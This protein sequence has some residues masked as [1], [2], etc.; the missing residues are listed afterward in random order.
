MYAILG[1]SCFFGAVDIFFEESRIKI[2]ISKKIV[3]RKRQTIRKDR[4]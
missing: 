4:T 3:S 2:R 1:K